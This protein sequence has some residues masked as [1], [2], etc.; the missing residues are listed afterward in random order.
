MVKAN[1]SIYDLEMLKKGIDPIDIHDD[2]G[3]GFKGEPIVCTTRQ[4]SDS[5]GNPNPVTKVKTDDGK[6]FDIDVAKAKTSRMLM[7][8][9]KIKSIT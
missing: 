1:D 5:A 6:E 2:G 8:T 4:S 9:D 3:E 7:T